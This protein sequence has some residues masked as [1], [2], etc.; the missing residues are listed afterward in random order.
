MEVAGGDKD[1]KETILALEALKVSPTTVSPSLGL[2][3]SPGVQ[4]VT[5]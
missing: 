5:T 3:S 4:R 2:F 1:G